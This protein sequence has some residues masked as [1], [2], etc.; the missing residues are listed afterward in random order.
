MDKNE[1]YSEQRQ[2]LVAQCSLV[3]NYRVRTQDQ[4]GSLMKSYL[5]YL[6]DKYQFM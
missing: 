2:D 3:L 5:F 4:E 6:Q 1:M